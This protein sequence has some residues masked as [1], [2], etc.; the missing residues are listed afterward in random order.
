[1]GEKLKYPDRKRNFRILFQ[2]IIYATLMIG[3][4]LVGAVTQKYIG[5]GNV[6]RNAGV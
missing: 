2:L 3:G 6:L 4:I 1:L 5:F